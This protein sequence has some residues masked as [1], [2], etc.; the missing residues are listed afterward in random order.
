MTKF[1][2]QAALGAAALV[3]AGAANACV[4]DFE[5]VDTSLALFAPL[6]SDG[7]AVIQGNYFV[8]TQDANKGGG[9]IG[10]L[11][12]GSDP[13]SCLNG[14]CPAGDASN[15]LS[16]YN[17]GIVH[18]GLLD[19][20]STVFSSLSAAYIAT[21]GNPAGSTVF[22]AIEADRADKTF[23]AFYFPLNGTGAFQTVTAAS[24]GT[25]FDGTGTLTSGSVTDLYVYSFFCDAS[26]GSCDAFTSDRGQFALDNI[27]MD[28]APVVAVPEP[29]EWMLMLAGLSAFAVF[30]RRR[31]SV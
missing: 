18:L 9:L 21:P 23:A 31:R 28:V 25:L 13:G 4:I 1:L 7:E 29:S 3:C 19:S 27:A 5:T 24:G 15:F 30:A 6:L 12:L 11:S 2:I 16:V 10:Q 22:L 17:D 14:V 8:Q 20:G 26:T